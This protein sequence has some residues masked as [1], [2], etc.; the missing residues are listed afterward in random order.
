M[1]ILDLHPKERHHFARF[2]GRRPQAEQ[3]WIGPLLPLPLHSLHPSIMSPTIA[4]PPL[5]AVAD[6]PTPSPFDAQVEKAHSR[7]LKELNRPE[8]DWQTMGERDGVLLSK[9]YDEE[10]RSKSL[11]PL[12]TLSSLL[13]RAFRSFR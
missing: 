11:S 4:Q 2:R 12:S 10:V 3:L 5:P 13:S 6:Y 9:H 8:E 1:A 7:F